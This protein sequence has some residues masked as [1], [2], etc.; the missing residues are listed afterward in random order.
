LWLAWYVASQVLGSP[1]CRPELRPHNNSLQ[2]TR[3]P[4]SRFLRHCGSPLNSISLG[5]SIEC[6]AGIALSCQCLV[7]V[8]PDSTAE[9][10]GPVRE[11][12]RILEG[13]LQNPC[14][15]Q[16]AS[17]SPVQQVSRLRSYRFSGTHAYWGPRWRTPDS[18]SRIFCSDA[19]MHPRPPISLQSSAP[20]QSSGPLSSW[21]PQAPFGL[22]VVGLTP[23][24][25]SLQ[26]TSMRRPVVVKRGR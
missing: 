15:F 1:W 26:R 23:P 21:Q 9:F 3:A 19:P 10:L 4:S 7:L 18:C 16:S 20:M 24:N 17:R 14:H 6:P 8:R 5:G 22:A 13:S 2:R 12:R 25:P 11:A